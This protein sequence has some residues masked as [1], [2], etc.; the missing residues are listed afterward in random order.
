[1]FRITQGKGSNEIFVMEVKRSLGQGN[2]FTPVCDWLCL[3]N[4]D[5]EFFY[6]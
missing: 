2:I 4:G 1:M 6:V 5:L 3:A